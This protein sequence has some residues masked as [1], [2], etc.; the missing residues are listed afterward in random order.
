MVDPLRSGR[1]RSAWPVHIVRDRGDPAGFGT[2]PGRGRDGCRGFTGP[3][4]PPLWMR[5]RGSPR[6]CSS[7]RSGKISRAAR[8]PWTCSPTHM[9]TRTSPGFA[10]PR[11][12]PR[13]ATRSCSGAPGQAISSPS[14]APGAS[15]TGAYAGSRDDAAGRRWPRATPAPAWRPSLSSPLAQ[16]VASTGSL[17]RRTASSGVLVDP[18]EE[19][20]ELGETARAELL[21]PIGFDF[22][23]RPSDHL[24]RGVAA[25]GE[26]N[27][28]RSQVIGMGLSLEVMQ[29]FKLSEQVV[30][31]LLADPEPG[32]QLGGPCALRS[33]ILEDVEVGGVEVVKALLVQPLEHAP[34]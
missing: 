25:F 18:E 14:C 2:F 17:A 12:P 21:R 29:P 19:T 27:P 16:A 8:V 34:L 11:W 3:V 20:A 4:P 28:F 13:P 1:R 32:G 26:D 15:T 22:P 10:P 31:G 23:H 7:H 24:D 6:R 5:R 30:E 33:W 9:C